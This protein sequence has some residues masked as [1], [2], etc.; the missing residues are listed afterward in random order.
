VPIADES[1]LDAPVWFALTGPQASVAVRLRSAARFDPGVSPFVGMADDRDASWVDL[2]R[3]LGASAPAVMFQPAHVPSDWTE[4]FSGRGL[5][6]IADSVEPLESLDDPEIIALGTADADEM[7]E[8]AGRTK[9]GPF[10]RRTV[11]LGGYVGVRRGGVLVAMAGERLRPPGFTEISAVCTDES[12]RGQGLAG[13]L[14]G[15]VASSI[16]AR[17]DRAFLHVAASNT[18]AVALYERLGFRV[19]REVGFAAY[20]S[21]EL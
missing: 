20:L 5:Q 14:V 4:T 16:A 15:R 9:P 1:V 18:A 7:F 2:G 11:E 17:G 3:L 12:V 19:R 8:L 13:R 21:P 6:M 10:E